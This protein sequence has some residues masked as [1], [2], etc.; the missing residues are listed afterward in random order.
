MKFKEFKDMFVDL[1]K[2]T[3]PHGSELMYYRNYFLP[4][5]GVTLFQEGENFY[6]VVG[7]GTSKSLFCAH[8]DTA[9]RI[10]KDI[11]HG[12][13]GNMIY[14]KSDTIL[15]ADDKAG[16]MVLLYMIYNNVPGTYYFFAGEECGRLGSEAAAKDY[17]DKFSKFERAVAFDRRGYGSIISNQMFS[18]CCSDLFVDSLIFE[19]EQ[20]GMKFKDDPTG[21]YT[22]TASFLGII[23]ECTN[24]SIGYDSE[25]SSK[26]KLNIN[27][28]WQVANAVCGIDWDGLPVERVPEEPYSYFSPRRY[29][30]PKPPKVR[31][32]S[33]VD[34]PAGTFS[35]NGTEYHPAPGTRYWKDSDEDDL[36][37]SFDPKD[38]EV[39]P[40]LTAEEAAALKK[41]PNI[42]FNSD[43]TVHSEENMD[44][45][46]MW[47]NSEDIS[48]VRAVEPNKPWSEFSV[49]ELFHIIGDNTANTL[50]LPETSNN[51]LENDE[52]LNPVGEDGNPISPPAVLV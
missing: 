13:S 39:P 36:D 31:G 14:T 34:R 2:V 52:L 46:P 43:G 21:S 45:P 6:H 12:F 4:S 19:F 17:Y 8:L 23:P 37:L 22:D 20:N 16:V 35:R 25:H 7:D 49:E 40:F 5:T 15:G 38:R 11:H 41:N 9:S 51:V 50:F 28:A 48:K 47:L 30:T 32:S 27:Y 33:P 29:T 18:E 26:E 42:T 24:I 44:E 10:C 1:T 3:V